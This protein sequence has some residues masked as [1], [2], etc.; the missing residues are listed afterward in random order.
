MFCRVARQDGLVTLVRRSVASACNSRRD[1]FGS[2]PI[3]TRLDC[4]KH[5]TSLVPLRLLPPEAVLALRD[6]Y[7]V[8]DLVEILR[9]ADCPDVN[10]SGYIA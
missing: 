4:R 5:G 2:A 8:R 9:A 6:T 1:K 7:L 3:A 10:R